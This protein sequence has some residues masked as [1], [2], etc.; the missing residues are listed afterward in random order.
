MTPLSGIVRTIAAS[1][2]LCLVLPGCETTTSM[3]SKVRGRSCA[4]RP[5]ESK[6]IPKQSNAVVQ[7][8][9]ASAKKR[10]Y[11][12]DK[13]FEEFE[14][15][16][17]REPWQGG[18]YIVDGDT[19]IADKKQ[20]QEFFEMR[21]KTHNRQAGSGRPTGRESGRWTRHGVEQ[22]PKETVDL[23]RQHILREPAHE[24]GCRNGGGRWR[25]GTDFG[26]KVRSCG[27]AGRDLRGIQSE[28]ALRCAPGEC[29]R[30]LPRPRLFPE[31]ASRG[32]QRLG[33]RE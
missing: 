2:S 13:T 27:L 24:D 15:S 26:C 6:L 23:L 12:K 5:T 29:E 1:V 18:K 17:Y 3:M 20:L 33:R 8:K 9:T 31:R 19:P 25:V 11:W 32:P 10:D 16:V 28:R 14:R 22:H 4:Q 30:G 7:I 21:V